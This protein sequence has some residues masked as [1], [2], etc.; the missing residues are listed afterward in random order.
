LLLVQNPRRP[1]FGQGNQG[2]KS[3]RGEGFLRREKKGF[4]RDLR[5][6]TID[7]PTH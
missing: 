6:N 2:K 3:S 4:R 1:P 7:S 5:V